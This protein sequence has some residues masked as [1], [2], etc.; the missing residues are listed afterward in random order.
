MS[1]ATMNMP[2]AGRDG[3]GLKLDP[4]HPELLITFERLTLASD[5]VA[6][7]LALCVGCKGC[8]RDCPTGVDM[9]RM[10]IEVLAQQRRARPLGIGQ[11]APSRRCCRRKSGLASSCWARS[12]RPSGSSRT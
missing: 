7:A 9:A 4:P 5:A 8:K 11:H 3:G 6:E 1:S 10:K 2:R 12:Y